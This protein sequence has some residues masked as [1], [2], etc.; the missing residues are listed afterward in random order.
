MLSYTG[1]DPPQGAEDTAM[2]LDSCK[3]SHL[4]QFGLSFTPF[5]IQ[6]A[7]GCYLYTSEN[8]ALL[9]WSSGQLAGILGHSHPHIVRA[10]SAASATLCHVGSAQLSPSVLKLAEKLSELVPKPLAKTMFLSTGS[11]ACEAAI[12]IAKACTEKW[13][14]I[15]LGSSWHGMTSA[16]LGAQYHS[17]RK[18]HGP[19]VSWHGASKNDFMEADMMLPIRCRATICYLLPTLIL[20]HSRSLMDRGIGRRS[21]ITA[22]A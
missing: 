7:R 15:G 12:R 9:D 1:R 6:R 16:S 19:T 13:E 14:I 22:G 5:V 4:L 3:P 20:H 17:G 11:E 21:W 8:H 2:L 18:N 10:L